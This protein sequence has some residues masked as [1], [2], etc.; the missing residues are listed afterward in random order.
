M[1]A[2]D[3][4]L[5]AYECIPHQVLEQDAVAMIGRLGLSATDASSG[6]SV[7]NSLITV[8]INM[9]LKESVTQMT[10][11]ERR[12][13]QTEFETSLF[14]KLSL[15]YI[16]NAVIIPLA[17]G[18]GI[19]LRVTRGAWPVTQSWYEG[20]GVVQ[21]AVPL[22]VS[23]GLITVL[24]VVQ[25]AI[26]LSRHV[27]ARC[28]VSQAKMN[29]LWEPPEMLL[30]E[31]YA[32]SLNL[33]RFPSGRSMQV[34]TTAPPSPHR[35]ASSLKT[36]GLCLVYAPLW[37]WAYLLTTIALLFN[38]GCTKVGVAYW[39]KKPPMVS[40]VLCPSSISEDMLIASL[41]AC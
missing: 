30:G 17:V 14:A 18:I 6:Y 4:A 15:A 35:Y 39:Y 19:S 25:P 13:T 41:S 7:F 32:S 34:L 9:L 27:L 1:I 23:N 33:L 2:S 21:V 11:W 3:C 38:Y 31:L 29:E 40:E 16:F 26:L 5:I 12:D 20:G 10:K 24:Q 8:V 22:I 37:P 36:V 28:V